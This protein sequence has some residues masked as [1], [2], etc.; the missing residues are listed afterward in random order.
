MERELYEMIEML[1][2]E[3]GP[4]VKRVKSWSSIR[5]YHRSWVY[6]PPFLTII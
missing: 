6:C 1:I 5:K 3:Q 4:I 2:S